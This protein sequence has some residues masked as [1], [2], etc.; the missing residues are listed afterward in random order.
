[1]VCDEE[2]GEYFIDFFP[3]YG[4]DD[5]GTWARCKVRLNFE[6]IMCRQYVVLFII[7]YMF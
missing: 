1:M 2:L 7:L 3:I 5:R 6:N 4:Q